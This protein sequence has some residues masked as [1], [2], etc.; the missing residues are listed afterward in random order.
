[1]ELSLYLSDCYRYGK[2]NWIN[3][4]IHLRATYDYLP[5]DKTIAKLEAYG[6]NS[7]NY[8]VVAFK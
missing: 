4:A 1:M 8:Y 3:E 7:I 6:F 2:R 5:H